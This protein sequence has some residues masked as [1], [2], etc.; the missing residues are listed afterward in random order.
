MK[1][2]KNSISQGHG[3]LDICRLA[4]H[5]GGN[6]V[7][8]IN[9]GIHHR[10]SRKSD[11]FHRPS[12]WRSMRFPLSLSLGRFAIIPATN[13]KKQKKVKLQSQTCW[14][15]RERRRGWC[16]TPHLNGFMF[17]GVRRLT[18]DQGTFANSS[19]K[20]ELYC[21]NVWVNYVLTER[22]TT[23]HVLFPSALFWK[24]ETCPS[25]GR[26]LR[27]GAREVF[28]FPFPTTSK[29]ICWWTFFLFLFFNFMRRS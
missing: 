14:R 29:K 3:K 25:S 8:E 21:T 7:A 28:L 18:Y 20:G 24:S 22:S 6:D 16:Q 27:A 9:H 10:G 17:S 23:W 12:L 15:E 5:P 11:N 1:L 13:T 26:L 4:W 2:W 19:S